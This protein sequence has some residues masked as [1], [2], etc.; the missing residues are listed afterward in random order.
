VQMLVLAVALALGGLAGVRALRAA[1]GARA[2]CAGEQIRGLGLG[3]EPCGGLAAGAAIPAPIAAIPASTDAPGAPPPTRRRP[4]VSFARGD[5]F[6]IGIDL[7]E[8]PGPIDEILETPVAIPP[9][10]VDRAGDA[11]GSLGGLADDVADGANDFVDDLVDAAETGKDAVVTGLGVADRLAPL[12]LSERLDDLGVGDSI[13]IAADGE[14]AA[15][16]GAAG[17]VSLVV[18]R[19][20][21]GF[22]VTASAGAQLGGSVKIF[23]FLGGPA[24]SAEFTFDTRAEAVQGLEGLLKLPFKFTPADPFIGP[25]GDEIA[26]L[27]DNVSAVELDATAVAEVDSLFGL[28]GLHAEGAEG[29]LGISRGARIEFEDGKP[30][31]L[32]AVVDV[33][34]AGAAEFSDAR[35]AALG[36]GLDV[37]NGVRVEASGSLGLEVRRSISGGPEGDPASLVDLVLSPGDVDLGPPVGTVRGGLEFELDNRGV[38]LGFEADDLDRGDVGAFVD[39]LAHG[40]VEGAIASTGS[41]LT[42]SFNTFEDRGLDTELDVGP[43]SL[44]VENSTRDAANQHDVQIRPSSPSDLDVFVDGRRLPFSDVLGAIGLAG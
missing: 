10:V 17:D 13:T 44:G 12:H 40:D 21:D 8:L 3:I 15:G 11:A 30:T 41:T 2:D 31:A 38:Q 19:T 34:A 5:G 35:L 7:P 39:R 27:V 28:S 32:V 42:G 24:V 23:D 26:T 9:V 43:A 29:A 14:L 33:T 36:L 1:M 16:L 37:P 4:D 22:Q 20:E 6:G 25:S 18:T